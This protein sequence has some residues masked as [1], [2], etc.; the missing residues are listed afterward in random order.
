MYAYQKRQLQMLNWRN[1]GGRWV[2]KAPAH[3]W[4]LESIRRVFP[5]A[6]FV[7]CHRHPVPVVASVNSMTRAIMDRYMGDWSHL[8]KAQIARAVMDWYAMSLDRGLTTREVMPRDM[9]VDCSQA[10]IADS[11]MTVVERI[12]Q[13]FGP[14]LED[15]SREAMETFARDNPKGKHGVHRYDLASFGLNE[16]TVEQ[17]FDFYLQDE[18]WPISG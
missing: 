12:Y 7:W 18:R 3:M 9:F 10:E 2:L 6:R 17:R 4:A 14:V 15:R 11:P 8:D 16:E 1:P 5:D 13:R